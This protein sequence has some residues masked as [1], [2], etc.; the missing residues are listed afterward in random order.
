MIYTEEAG[1]SS[2]STIQYSVCN[3]YAYGNSDSYGDANAD[4][5]ARPGACYGGGS[6]SV[7]GQHFGL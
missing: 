1:T 4:G 2:D 7:F 6:D 3:A 5:N